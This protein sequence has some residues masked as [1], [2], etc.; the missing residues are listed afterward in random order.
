MAS[1]VFTDDPV[2][3]QAPFHI[4]ERSLTDI[5][6]LMSVGSPEENVVMS[7]IKGPC[8]FL[9]GF[10]QSETACQLQN[11]W[12][13]EVLAETSG[14]YSP[15]VIEEVLLGPD[16]FVRKFVKGPAHPF[17]NRNKQKGFY[18]KA[19]MD[20]EIPFQNDFL[21]FVTKGSIARPKV[22]SSYNVSIE[23]LPTE[24]NQTAKFQPHATYLELQCADR[25]TR[26]EN[27][28]FPVRKN[29]AWSPEACGDLLLQIEV[30]DIF[31]TRRYEG[32]NAFAKFIRDFQRGGKVFY[33]R[34]FPEQK[35][36]LK[37]I[38]VSSIKVK[39]R[40][41]GQQAVSDLARPGPGTAPNVIAACWD[42]P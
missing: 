41:T 19:V 31:L 20:G 15:Q 38:G 7:L 5:Q 33:P 40:F 22:K 21:S 28:N 6:D 11:I 16:G 18:P 17:L 36:R 8:E 12:E 37:T 35:S 26:L 29:F 25:S 32:R 9:W 3:S 14:L 1:D 23:G 24:A 30:G 27:Y 13:T 39:Y 42:K 2:T 10:V 34:D 4:A